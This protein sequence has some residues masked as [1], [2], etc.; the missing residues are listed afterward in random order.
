VARF[1]G[2]QRTEAYSHVSEDEIQI[3]ADQTGI[4]V[5]FF[6]QPSE[7]SDIFVNCKT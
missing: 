1:Y 4:I 2:S 6:H 5:Y 7:G 3:T